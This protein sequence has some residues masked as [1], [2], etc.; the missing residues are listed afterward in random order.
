[1]VSCLMGDSTALA[2]AI[3]RC[4]LNHVCTY[5]IYDPIS[6]LHVPL[7]KKVG[8]MLV[9]KYYVRHNQFPS[10]ECVFWMLNVPHAPMKL[11]LLL[12]RLRGRVRVMMAK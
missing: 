8:I 6:I 3:V 2:S 11:T 7:E 9:Y 1:M 10:K 4:C 5:H 12:K